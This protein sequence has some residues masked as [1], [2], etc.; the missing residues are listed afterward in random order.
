MLPRAAAANGSS[1]TRSSSYVSANRRHGG[2]RPKNQSK[3]SF[4]AGGE[5]K[6]ATQKG[7]QRKRNESYFG[8]SL[9]WVIFAGK[10]EI[11]GPTNANRLV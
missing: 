2:L 1:Q 6:H 4:C 11:A 7:E 5:S 8:F 9:L 3:N 10:P